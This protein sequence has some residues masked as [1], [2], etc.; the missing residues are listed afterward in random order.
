GGARL[1]LSLHHEHRARIAEAGEGDG[2]AGAPLDALRLAHQ[3]AGGGGRL[4]ALHEGLLADGHGPSAGGLLR[5]AAGAVGGVRA[6]P[7]CGFGAAERGRLGLRARGTPAGWNLA[8][9]APRGLRPAQRPC[10]CHGPG[11]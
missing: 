8:C 1:S 5:G 2:A 4:C 10:L 9:A 7:L 11:R 3:H 6:D